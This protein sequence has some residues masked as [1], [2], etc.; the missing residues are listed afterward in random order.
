MM[1][2][3]VYIIL[4]I[5]NNRVCM[6]M[7]KQMFISNAISDMIQTTKEETNSYIDLKISSNSCLLT[8]S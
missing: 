4:N 1:H 5:N 2:V 8:K 7:A 3:H 6:Y